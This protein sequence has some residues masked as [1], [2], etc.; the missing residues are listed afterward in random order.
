MDKLADVVLDYYFFL[1]FCSD[2][3]MEP[4]TA[5]NKIEELAYAI[6]HDFSDAEKKALQ[7]AAKRSL[8]FMLREPD[9]HGYTPRAL[10]TPEQKEFLQAIEG[11]HFSG[12]PIDGSE[13]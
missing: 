9:K 6:T 3:E 8:A 2:E 7:D 4:D 10:V 5:V 13:G 1:N 12:P 11:G